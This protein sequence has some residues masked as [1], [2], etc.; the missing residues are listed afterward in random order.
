[1]N[2]LR[3]EGRRNHSPRARPDDSAH[4][5]DRRRPRGDR[6]REAR[7]QVAPVYA[8]SQPIAEQV[9]GTRYVSG[10]VGAAARRL[11]P[12]SRRALS[13]DRASGPLPRWHW[14]AALRYFAAEAQ[15]ARIQAR[16]GWLPILS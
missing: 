9:L 10:R 16:T 5:R 4:C 3:P 12:A 6:R 14:A 8:I 13:A 11:R 7:F 2:S 1:E 15:V